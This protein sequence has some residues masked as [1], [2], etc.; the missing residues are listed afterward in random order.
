MMPASP[1][2]EV[3]DDLRQRAIDVIERR[4]GG[5]QRAHFAAIIIQRAYRRWRMQQTW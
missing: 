4:Y 5:R 1:T 3:S 2:Y